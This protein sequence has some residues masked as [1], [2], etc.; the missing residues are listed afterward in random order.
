MTAR[1]RGGMSLDDVAREFGP[2]RLVVVASEE[3]RWMA[4]FGG[5]ADP[6]LVDRLSD[7]QYCIM[8]RIGRSRYEWCLRKQLVLRLGRRC[9]Y[10]IFCSLFSVLRYHG[11]ITQGESSLGVFGESVKT[12]HYHRMYL[13]KLNLITKQVHTQRG[14][15]NQLYQG[16]LL[17][18]KR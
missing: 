17:M 7:I 16:S 14:M 2:E 5:E 13:L 18:L 8:E 4:L 10:S 12:M 3:R 6:Q 15:N 11:E 1:V 9:H